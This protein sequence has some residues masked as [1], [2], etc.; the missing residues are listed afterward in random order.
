MYKQSSRII[1]ALERDKKEELA[2][3]RGWEFSKKGRVVAKTTAIANYFEKWLGSQWEIPFRIKYLYLKDKI[4]K[5]IRR[6]HCKHDW[7]GH[8][9]LDMNN[10]IKG[11]GEM[12]IEYQCKR[13][14]KLKKNAK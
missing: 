5:F 11:N 3:F 12:V 8:T 4:I 7:W 13:C 1:S 2:K 10:V 14:G 6:I 9:I